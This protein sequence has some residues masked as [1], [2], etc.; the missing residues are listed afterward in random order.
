[1]ILPLERMA[2]RDSHKRA[3]E[4][5][6]RKTGIRVG[7]P[8]VNEVELPLERRTNQRWKVEGGKVSGGN[9]TAWGSTY[10]ATEIE[11]HMMW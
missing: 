8:N 2:D 11:N 5:E 4:V 10:E 3:I 9:V 6:L 1:L 7:E